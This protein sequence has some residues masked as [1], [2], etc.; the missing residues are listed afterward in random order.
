[1]FTQ[2]LK[3]KQILL[4]LMTFLSFLS[5]V[6]CCCYMLTLFLKY[7]WQ[8]IDKYHRPTSWWHSIDEC[9]ATLRIYY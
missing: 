7:P 4:F 6:N 8:P 3:Q 1:M 2:N 9:L 5:Y